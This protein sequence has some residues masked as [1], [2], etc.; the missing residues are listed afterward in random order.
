[1]HAVIGATQM[2]NLVTYM[3]SYMRVHVSTDINY[4]QNIWLSSVG[5][6]AFALFTIAGGYLT[7]LIPFRGV[8][9]IG[10]FTVW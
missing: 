10:L 1:M 9:W 5:V 2:G 3:T 7:R 4:G 6:T 8:V